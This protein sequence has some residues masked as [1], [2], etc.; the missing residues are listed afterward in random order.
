M[1]WLPKILSTA[2]NKTDHIL[3]V[4]LY[5]VR[6]DMRNDPAG[7]LKKL[8][9]AGF[10]YVEHA[11]YSGRKFYGYPPDDFKKLLNDTGLKMETVQQPERT[12]PLWAYASRFRRVGGGNAYR[13]PRT[14]ARDTAAGRQRGAG[15]RTDA[16]A[17]EHAQD[18]PP[19][20]G[21]GAQRPARRD[22]GGG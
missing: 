21:D 14:S 22:R 16:A 6:N 19:A 2:Q 5:S 15:R 1:T 11:G 17:G 20:V 8:K 4:Q 9:A 18:D 3:G 13:K 10:E 12:A 7:T